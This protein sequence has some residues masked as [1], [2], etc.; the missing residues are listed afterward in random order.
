M[1]NNV[2]YLKKL[3]GSACW[4]PNQTGPGGKSLLHIAA[5]AN[6]IEAVEWLLENKASPHL[7]DWGLRT[8]LHYA[9]SYKVAKLLLERGAHVNASDNWDQT[10]LSLM[11][12]IDDTS[13]LTLM[14]DHGARIHSNDERQP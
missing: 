4:N 2:R 10:P 3:S 5:E 6:A 1:K 9:K 11:L 7:R 8:P 13:L 12:R 14:R